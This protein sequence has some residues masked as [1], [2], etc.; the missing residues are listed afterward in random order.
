MT[1]MRVATFSL[2]SQMLQASM[3]A[4]ARMS[5]LQ[6]QEASG[7]V[8]FDYGGL[9]GKAGDVIDLETTTA[10]LTTYSDAATTAVNRI[11]TAYDAMSSITDLLTNFTSTL[12]SSS[13]GSGAETVASAA[14]SA[15]DELIALLNTQFNGR[16]LFAGSNTGNEAVSLDGVSYDMTTLTTTNS[17]YYQGN[18]RTSS[19]RVSSSEVVD[20]GLTANQSGLEKALRVLAS[21]ATVTDATLTDDARETGMDLLTEALDEILAG[22]TELSLDAGRLEAAIERNENAVSLA[23][24]L[25]SAATEVDIAEVAVEISSYETQLE[26]SYAALAKILGLSLL[27]FLS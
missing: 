14:E 18:D 10:R 12:S 8:S 20:Y 24:E 16:Y 22:Q 9:G 3:A 15:R 4:N 1:A 13:T 6:L 2:S 26:A 17:D 23:G 11:E 25:L 27:D 7:L 5:E 19:V 21:F